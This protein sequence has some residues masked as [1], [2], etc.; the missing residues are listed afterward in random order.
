MSVSKLMG[1]FVG[2]LGISVLIG[3]FEVGCCGFGLVTY[4]RGTCPGTTACCTLP[5][6]TLCR[7][8]LLGSVCW[9]AVAARKIE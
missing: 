4:T 2:A 6:F 5:V 9:L 8:F 7:G 1:V 3:V